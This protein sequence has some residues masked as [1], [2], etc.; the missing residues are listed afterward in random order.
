MAAWDRLELST[1][2]LEDCL[3]TVGFL[4]LCEFCVRNSRG[5]SGRQAH[6]L[7]EYWF[8]IFSLIILWPTGEL[9]WTSSFE[10]HD[11]HTDALLARRHTL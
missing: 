1:Y 10:P 11:G 9:T 7:C 5:L 6:Y 8:D 2:C 3:F 4:T